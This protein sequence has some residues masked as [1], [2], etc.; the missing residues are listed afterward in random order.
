VD[1]NEIMM[2]NVQTLN[3]EPQP[4]LF[5]VVMTNILITIN[6]ENCQLLTKNTH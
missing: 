1:I 2:V 4:V 6:T 5:D 3:V